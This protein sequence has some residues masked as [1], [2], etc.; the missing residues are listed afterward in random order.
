MNTSVFA[1]EVALD[2]T[3]EA[4]VVTVDEAEAEAEA[5]VDAAGDAYETT[6]DKKLAVEYKE[7]TTD[8]EK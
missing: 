3:D 1:E 7:N 8:K 6:G 5:T 2:S 4:A